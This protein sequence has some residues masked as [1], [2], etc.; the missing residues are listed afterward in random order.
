MQMQ[1]CPH[2]GR[3][4][5]SQFAFCPG[6][7]IRL[8]EQAGTKP[9]PVEPAEPAEVPVKAAAKPKASGS[10][11]DSVPSKSVT[12]CCRDSGVPIAAASVPDGFACDGAVQTSGGN[13]L[14][15][16][17]DWVRAVSPNG[18]LTLFSES[19]MFWE[20]V[21][22]EFLKQTMKLAGINKANY[23]EFAG[24]GRF[25]QDYA[26]SFLNAE[27]A[28]VARA[29]LPGRFAQNR[30]AIRE[31]YVNTFLLKEGNAPNVHLEVINSVCEPL[32]VKFAEKKGSRIVLL[33][34]EFMGIEYRNTI[35]PMAVMGG[36]IGLIGS[37]MS[38][39]PSKPSD[40]SRPFG[41]GEG[42]QVIRWGYNRMYLCAADA[43]EEA[44]ATQAFLRFVTSFAPD[45]A[46]SQRRA[47]A[48]EQ[49]YQRAM[50]QA[51]ALAAQARQGQIMAQQRA[52]ET[53]RII[54]QN[55]AEISAGIMDSWDRKMASDSRISSSMSEAIRGV[56]TWQTTDGRSVEVD[57]TADHVYQNTYGDVYGVSGN[58]VDPE[59]LTKLDWTELK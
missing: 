51:N 56:N 43:A 18:R 23:N 10:K 45:S 13:D 8:E 1:F 48:E 17:R 9:V 3:K 6:C 7:G 26:A 47:Q 37:L 50:Q 36:T 4:L 32:L 41:Q 39:K 33:G 15:Q 11:A 21:L 34:C 58:A 16:L 57:V 28:P 55:S 42:T 29:E 14:S 49:I 31:N 53:S 30:T 27:L 38:M 5:E 52:M 35:N 20:T 46:L 40:G 59:I 22:S 19:H 25:L 54:A 44:E 24:I 12:F 2:C